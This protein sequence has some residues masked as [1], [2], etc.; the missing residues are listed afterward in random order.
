MVGLSALFVNGTGLQLKS[1]SL[2]ILIF[3]INTKVSSVDSSLPPW[4]FW[5][6]FAVPL[7]PIL[8]MRL[9]LPISMLSGITSY[10]EDLLIGFFDYLFLLNCFF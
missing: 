9:W 3:L 7:S 10:P 4:S 6:I 2:G 8:W 5:R 1:E